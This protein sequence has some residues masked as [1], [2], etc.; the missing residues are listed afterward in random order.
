MGTSAHELGHTLG[1]IHEQ[2]RL[3]RDKHI[4]IHVDR[5]SRLA[6]HNFQVYHGSRT[7]SGVSYDLHSIMH[8][9]SAVG[10]IDK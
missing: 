4:K 6:L 1:L 10:F 3:D 2:S 7:P 8:Y 9:N 5:I